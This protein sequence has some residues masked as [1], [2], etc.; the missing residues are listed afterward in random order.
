MSLI[1]GLTNILWIY[2][3]CLLGKYVTD[4][5]DR[6]P[7]HLFQSRWYDLPIRMQKYFILLLADAQNPLIFYGLGIY[8][9]DLETFT[10]VSRGETEE[11]L[12]NNIHI[13]Y[14]LAFLIFRRWIE[15]VLTI[16]CS[17]ALNSNESICYE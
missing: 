9:L 5:F 8:A 2:F 17:E 12:L 7:N 13:H 16:W 11:I 1:A 4:R 3:H 10:S 6:L 14:S 15:F